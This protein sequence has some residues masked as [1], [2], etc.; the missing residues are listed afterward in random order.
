[1][2]TLSKH[3]DILIRI[4]VESHLCLT[5]A[6]WVKRF[7][8]TNLHIVCS[9]P[10]LYPVCFSV[11]VEIKVFLFGRCFGIRQT[12]SFV[13]YSQHSYE[14][15]GIFHGLTFL[16]ICNVIHHFAVSSAKFLIETCSNVFPG[17]FSE[18]SF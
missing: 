17:F 8:L 1:M 13:I 5:I 16:S 12:H 10:Y 3:L 14:M 18:Y 4:H 15:V 6:Y 9:N 2:L 7:F 11:C